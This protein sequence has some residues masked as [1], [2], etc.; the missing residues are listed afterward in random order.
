[1]AP[2]LSAHE[3]AM[4]DPKLLSSTNATEVL[5]SPLLLRSL[6]EMGIQR[7]T[8]VQQQTFEPIYQGKSLCA[9][10][11]T[12]SGKTL[13][14]LLPILDQLLA[15]S[16]GVTN[17]QDLSDLHQNNVFK[18]LS[19]SESG[20]RVLILVPT[21]ELGQQITEQ[22]KSLLKHRPDAL[23]VMSLSGGTTS[24][25]TDRRT[26]GKLRSLPDILVATPGR[27]LDLVTE[28]PGSSA[29]RVRGRKFSDILS[30]IKTVILDE[31]D[32]LLLEGFQKETTRIL[33]VLPRAEKRQTLL[34]S[35][36]MSDKMKELSSTI[37]P[38]DFAEVD[39][40]GDG[41]SGDRIKRSFLKIPSMDCYTTSLIQIVRQAMQRDTV[42]HKILVFFPTARL[43]RFFAS[44]VKD[45]MD[46]PVLEIHSRMSQSARNKARS[47][48]T[49]ATRSVM[50]TSDVSARGKFMS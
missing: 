40:V 33:S 7:L 47:A 32:R 2:I 4:Q 50:F 1:V 25:G 38:N 28:R 21:R 30:E 10:S 39:C 34:F 36:T 31:A 19:S 12:G 45:A 27:L 37:L 41:D 24:L 5:Q 15:N 22:I 43:V 13:A 29:T 18:M 35:A 48:F 6:R 9:R 8:R 44:L 42:R 17:N 11:K 26:L 3:Q 49:S 16:N 20:T 46:I 14:F 23:S